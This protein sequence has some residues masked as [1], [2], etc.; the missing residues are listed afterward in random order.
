LFRFVSCPCGYSSFPRDRSFDLLRV[1][2]ER[3]S[4]NGLFLFW[5]CLGTLPPRRDHP[6]RSVPFRCCGT[7]SRRSPTTTLVR[8]AC[9]GRVS[10]SPRVSFV[11][12]LVWF[13]LLSRCF[14]FRETT[15]IAIASCRAMRARS[16]WKKPAGDPI[17]SNPLIGFLALRDLLPLGAPH[18]GL[19]VCN[20]SRFHSRSQRMESNS[21]G[22]TPRHTTPRHS[23]DRTG[24]PVALSG[25]RCW[26]GGVS[27]NV[28]CVC[29]CV[30][31]CVHLYPRLPGVNGSV[32]PRLSMIRASSVV[33]GACPNSSLS[34]LRAV[35]ASKEEDERPL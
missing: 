25:N 2:H 34:L 33:V 10:L 28:V 13:C 30:F 21:L 14:L 19:S 20:P 29:V 22:A 31:V 3:R 6:C 35:F 24:F 18:R 1:R 12:G 9:A 17:H 15:V 5:L 27:A 23:I 16:R 11:V 4:A 8:V 26:W 7:R 32:D